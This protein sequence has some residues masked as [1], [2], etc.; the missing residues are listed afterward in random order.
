MEPLTTIVLAGGASSRM[1]QPKALLPFGSE[2]LIERIVRRLAAGSSEIVV[3]SGPHVRL[4]PLPDEVR[5]VADEVPLQGPVAGIRYGLMA[6]R[7]ELGFV[8]GC[9]HPFVEPALGRLLADRTR[10]RDGAIVVS[11]GVPQP[12]L[13]VYRKRV[14]TIAATMLASGE[15]RAV[16]LGEH[17]RLVQLSDEDLFAVD[18]SGLSLLDVDTPQAYRD[19]LARLDPHAR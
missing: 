15:R 6:A 17:A 12:L 19:A 13:A 4:P 3:V 11:K 7:T 9:D 18:P 16:R 2:T 14:A 8:C 10:D 1:G 5:V